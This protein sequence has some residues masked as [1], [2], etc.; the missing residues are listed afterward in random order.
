M[1]SIDMGYEQS[2]VG[3]IDTRIDMQVTHSVIGDVVLQVCRHMRFEPISKHS[4][5]LAKVRPLDGQRTT[6]R[7]VQD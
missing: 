4:H 1:H 2:A 3:S 6:E 5:A 7:L